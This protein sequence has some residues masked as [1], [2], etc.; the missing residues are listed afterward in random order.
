M[1]IGKMFGDF[2]NLETDILRKAA[3]PDANIEELLLE[4]KRRK[5]EGVNN[6]LNRLKIE[7][8][9]LDRTIGNIKKDVQSKMSDFR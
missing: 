4:L 7:M 2:K 6:E 9:Y 3:F 8:K 5:S 1:M